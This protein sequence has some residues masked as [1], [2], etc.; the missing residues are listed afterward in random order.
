LHGLLQQTPST[1]SVLLHS[2]LAL[3]A[4]PFA[5]F[6]RHVPAEH[7]PSAG[8]QSAEVVQPVVHA[9]VALAHLKGVQSTPVAF[10]AQ[11]ALVPAQS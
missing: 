9:P 4:S 1:Q 7:Q 5:L 8:S 11:V 6:F 10:A 2:S 3:H